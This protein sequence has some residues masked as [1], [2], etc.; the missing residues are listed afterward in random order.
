MNKPL[1][2]GCL[3]DDLPDVM[4]PDD[5]AADAGTAGVGSLSAPFDRPGEPRIGLS[6]DLHH[7]ETAPGD[8]MR[9]VIPVMGARLGGADR[10]N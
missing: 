2:V 3:S 9:L 7:I 6:L 10:D 8:A 1:P 5:D 4:R